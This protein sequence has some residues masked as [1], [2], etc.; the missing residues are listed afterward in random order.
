MPRGDSGSCSSTTR[1]ISRV[2]RVVML[3]GLAGSLANASTFMVDPTQIFLTAGTSSRLLTIR[4]DSPETLR[5]QLTAFHWTQS[6]RG[7]MELAP[8]ED[9]VFFPSLL[10]LGPKQERKV[11]V[12]AVTSFDATEKTYRLFV[13]ELPP[14]EAEKE[15]PGVK[16]LMKMG[17]P[18]FL[19][20]G[21]AE[22]RGEITNLTLRE[23][24]LSFGLRNAGNVHFVPDHIQLKGLT[25][26]G[27]A[28]IN[29]RLDAWYVLAGGIR[30]YEIMLPAPDCATVT[31]LAVE[32]RVDG[33]TLTNSLQTPGG[34]CAP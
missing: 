24:V 28:L 32:V 30:E 9:I 26:S 13:E 20:G 19:R 4:N 1:A 23:G 2:A 16:V 8:T 11:R 6:A 7:E 33:S 31:S 18:I 25:A 10:M 27:Q 3:I 12:G 17:I 34:V 29:G 5:F 14:I 15:A 21:R 22:S